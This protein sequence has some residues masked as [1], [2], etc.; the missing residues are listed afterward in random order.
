M[1]ERK[2]LDNGP[3]TGNTEE[4]ETAGGLQSEALEALKVRR[5]PCGH[6]LDRLVGSL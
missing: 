5:R 2:R 4:R 1:V 6:R 3:E